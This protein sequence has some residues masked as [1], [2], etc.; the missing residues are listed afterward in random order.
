MY[1][2]MWQQI[3]KCGAQESFRQA[4]LIAQAGGQPGPHRQNFSK[5]LRPSVHGQGGAVQAPCTILKGTSHPLHEGKIY[6]AIEQ[7]WN[8]PW[9]RIFI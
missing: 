9:K 4:Q 8:L 1:A 6:S 7:P 5:E 2:T 3:P